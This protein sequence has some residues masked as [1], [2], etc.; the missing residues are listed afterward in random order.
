MSAD[1]RSLVERAEHLRAVGRLDDAERTVRDGLAENPQDPALLRGLAVLL[2]ASD[3]DRPDR[4]EEGLAAADAACAAE[5]GAEHPH[6]LRALHLSMLGRHEEALEA[7]YRAV[8]LAPD[9]RYAATGYARVL[10]RAGRLA[11]AAQVARRVVE[12]GPLEAGSHFLLADVTSDL[13]D[14][15]TARAAY[16]ETLRLDPAH[17]GARHDLAVLDARS[18]RPGRALGGLV[19][20]GR[21]APGETGVLGTVAAVLWQLS[22]RLRLVLLVSV[23]LVLALSA[24]PEGAAVATR[25]GAVAVLLAGALLARHET[26]ELPRGAWPVIRAAVRADRPLAVT[27]FALGLCVALYVAVAL[28]GIAALAGAVWVVLLG[29]ALLAVGVGLARRRRSGR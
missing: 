23:F 6:R 29:L 17:A 21:L 11:D 12:L 3:R 14:A 28:T 8:S 20:A 15:A 2:L 27:W 24:R 16:T 22:W 1:P 26:R 13:G 25:V 19:D 4:H 7:G 18:H 9:D 10:Q 5:P